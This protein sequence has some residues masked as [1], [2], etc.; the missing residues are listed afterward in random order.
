MEDGVD[1]GIHSMCLLWEQHEQEEYWIFLLIDA[2][3]VFNEDN[4]IGMLWL[5]NITGSVVRSLLLSDT[6]TAPLWW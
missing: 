4:R 6:A 1:D 3:N 5:S 2:Q